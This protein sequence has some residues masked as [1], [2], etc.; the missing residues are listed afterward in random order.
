MTSVLAPHRIVT[1]AERPDL[2][3]RMNSFTSAA[4]PVFMHHDTV[5]NLYWKRLYPDFSAYQF[6]M[7]DEAELILAVGN[8]VPISWIESF[9]QL[10]DTGWDWEVETAFQQIDAAIEPTTLCAVQI[11]VDPKLR[12]S[13]LSRRMVILMRDLAVKHRLNALIAPVRPN[14]KTL[15]PLTP[16]D[17]YVTWKRPDGSLFDPWLR[18]HA[19]L[20]ARM[21]G[22]CHH[23]MTI[24]GSIA[25]WQKWTGLSFPDSGKYVVPGALVPI[26]IDRGQD[27]GVYI[28]PN[29]WMVHSVA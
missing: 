9:E 26:S 25:D 8:S 24:P 10:P 13:G 7:L 23:A 20:G 29:V 21:I 2:A 16:M 17:R 1:A 15:Y 5:S 28:E 12:G 14:Q 3:D 18:V 22:V 11:V 6:A 27:R 4:W 19:S